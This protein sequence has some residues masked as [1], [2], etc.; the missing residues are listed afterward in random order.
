MVTD[1]LA[2]YGDSVMGL[3]RILAKVYVRKMFRSTEVVD[4]VGVGPEKVYEAG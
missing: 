4:T 3:T 2:V 1:Y